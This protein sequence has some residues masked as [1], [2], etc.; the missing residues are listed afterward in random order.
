ME[1]HWVILGDDK[2]GRWDWLWRRFFLMSL[3]IAI[4]GD[5][6]I[7]SSFWV[8]S[9]CS[10]YDMSDV[11]DGEFISSILVGVSSFGCSIWSCSRVIFDNEHAGV[12]NWDFV[13]SLIFCSFA[14]FDSWIPFKSE[15]WGDFCLVFDSFFVDIYCVVGGCFRFY[16]RTFSWIFLSTIYLQNWCYSCY[17]FMLDNAVVVW[18]GHCWCWH[19]VH[20][21]IWYIHFGRDS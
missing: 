7:S 14:V 16:C 6:K 11:I 2:T 9:I 17:I 1:L 15:L 12:H 5:N 19:Y 18:V 21:I 13:R 3:A 8:V 4:F 10:I 20:L